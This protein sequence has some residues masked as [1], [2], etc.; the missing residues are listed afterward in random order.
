MTTFN[1]SKHAK[2]ELSCGKEATC[3]T[4]N[5]S[6]GTSLK[7]CPLCSGVGLEEAR[8]FKPCRKCSGFGIIKEGTSKEQTMTKTAQ[9]DPDI[10]ADASLPPAPDLEA[11]EPADDTVSNPGTDEEEVA[12]FDEVDE[13]T[14]RGEIWRN[15]IMM[16]RGSYEDMVSKVFD[17][18]VSDKGLHVT[19]PSDV[20]DMRTIIQKSIVNMS[21]QD[22]KDVL[23][24]MKDNS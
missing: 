11:T 14:D 24:F 2:D 13:V 20:M 10:P 4:E 18:L 21:D 3:T 19:K 23:K 8:G 9:I 12:D 22:M 7:L 6:K 17:Y 15:I 5:K 16:I 1:L